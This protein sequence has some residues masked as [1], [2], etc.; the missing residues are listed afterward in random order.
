VVASDHRLLLGDES[1][2]VADRTAQRLRSFLM[3]VVKM[4]PL[5]ERAGLQ[6]SAQKLKQGTD[7]RILIICALVLT[8]TVGL[9]GCFHHQKA[10]TQEPLKLG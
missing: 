3:Y 5:L 6:L 9:G 8:G 2:L 10:V 4:S 1:A 7:M